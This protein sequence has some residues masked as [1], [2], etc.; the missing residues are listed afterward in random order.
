MDITRYAI[1]FI[2]DGALGN[3]GG[4]WFG[5]DPQVETRVPFSNLEGLMRVSQRLSKRPGNRV[6]CNF[7]ITFP[8]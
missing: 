4:A 5:L 8:S 2:T 1:Y 6:A 3:F 7:K